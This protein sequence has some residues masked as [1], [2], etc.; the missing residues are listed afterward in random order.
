MGVDKDLDRG[1]LAVDDCQMGPRS[2]ID[3]LRCIFL[4]LALALSLPLEEHLKITTSVERDL[5]S[6]PSNRDLQLSLALRSSDPK[7]KR[8]VCELARHLTGVVGDQEGAILYQAQ[9]QRVLWLALLA[10][11][12]LQVHRALGLVKNG[13]RP[14]TR[15]SKSLESV[16]ILSEPALEL[17][18]R[19]IVDELSLSF[20]HPEVEE[21]ILGL[22]E[23]I[24]PDVAADVF[25]FIECRIRSLIDL[26]DAKISLWV[27]PCEALSLIKAKVASACSFSGLYFN[28]LLNDVV[29]AEPVA[30]A[31]RDHG[32][33]GTCRCW[34]S[35]AVLP[36]SLRLDW[37]ALD[38]VD[39][40]GLAKGHVE[41]L[42]GLVDS[43]RLR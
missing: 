11:L 17:V 19:N 23:I 21:D 8:E 12:V 43:A 7:L 1:L 14:R 29:M 34:P 28:I 10:P 42:N 33:Q 15:S 6:L 13:I 38:I 18:V 20:V 9:I 3:W 26:P 2:A 27:L 36:M 40:R 39:E 31:L 25:V 41:S 24:C 5:N 30:H 35:G 37:C 32:S 16:S 4:E 22:I